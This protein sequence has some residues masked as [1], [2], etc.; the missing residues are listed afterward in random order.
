MEYVDLICEKLNLDELE[1][2]KPLTQLSDKISVKVRYIAFTLITLVSLFIVFEYGMSWFAFGV[3]FLYPAYMTFKAMETEEDDR[4]ND[5]LWMTYWI[6][7]SVVNTFDRFLSFILTI[8]PFYNF[9]K[10]VFYVWM[11]H[12][13][14]KGAYI[15]YNK[16][17]RKI[18]K[19]YESDIDSKLNNISKTIDDAAPI[20]KDAAENL[21]KKGTD[22]V[23]KRTIQ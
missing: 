10:I 18:L 5:R 17:I 22:E 1:R 2:I 23:V 19:K 3:G 8:I 20:L 13:K 16:V 12:P 4:E 9:L 15:V 11:F 7:F 21:K 14:T 6:V